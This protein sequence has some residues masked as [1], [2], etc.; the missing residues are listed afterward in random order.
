M[1]G[2][3]GNQQQFEAALASV[4]GGAALP[5]PVKAKLWDTVQ[6]TRVGQGLPPMTIAAPGSP[7][8]GAP[9]VGGQQPVPAN[10]AAAMPPSVTGQAPPAPASR[11]PVPPRPAPGLNRPDDVPKLQAPPEPTAKYQAPQ[12]ETASYTAP[13]YEPPKKGLEYAAMALALLFPGAPIAKDAAAFVQGLNTGAADKYKR[14]ETT[15]QNQYKAAEAKDATINQGRIAQAAGNFTAAQQY[16]KWVAA[17][18]AVGNENADRVYAARQTERQQGQNPDTHKPF[19]PPGGLSKPPPPTTGYDGL[20]QWHQARALWYEQQGATGPAAQEAAAAKEATTQAINAANNARALAEAAAR[21]RQELASHKD[22]EAGED[23]RHND[24][25][26]HEDQRALL[27]DQ[28]RRAEYGVKAS[29]ADKSLFTTWQQYTKPQ[30]KTVEIKDVNGNVT[31]IRT[32]PL[33]D[34]NGNPVPPP[35]SGTLQQTI[36]KMVNLVR[37]DRDPEGA[38]AYYAAQLDNSPG[39]L[40]GKEILQQAGAAGALRLMAGGRLPQEHAFPK[41][42]EQTTPVNHAPAHAPA[43]VAAQPAAPAVGL[44]GLRQHPLPPAPPHKPTAAEIAA[45]QATKNFHH[46]LG[47]DAAP[48]AGKPKFANPPGLPAGATYVGPGPTGGDEYQFPDGSHQEYTGP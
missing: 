31:G 30:T 37:G 46:A 7:P 20:A 44:T 24:T 10:V 21:M 9:I 8:G 17:K 2:T 42:V 45:E 32:V 40:A 19:V 28:G 29:N 34:A 16:D 22:T 1:A 5:N 47:M 26:W 27:V 4:P 25:V 33:V 12:L 41:I 13:K 11:A 15:A 3:I 43:P 23:R 14:A 35:I 18:T 36:T 48:A 38:A 6:K 39:G